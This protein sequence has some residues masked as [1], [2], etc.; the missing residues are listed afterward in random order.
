MSTPEQPLNKICP[1]CGST[2]FMA[3]ITRGGIVK[4]TAVPGDE[5]GN[6]IE[7]MKEIPDKHDVA[8][9]KCARCRNDIT[10]EDLTTGI[11][12]KSCGTDTPPDDIDENGNCGVCAALAQRTELQTASKEDLIRMLIEAERKMNPVNAQIEKKQQL[13]ENTINTNTD[14]A[15]D[16]TQE[17]QVESEEKPQRKTRKRK[18]A[19]ATAEEN[20]IEEEAAEPDSEEA[21]E[22]QE[23]PAQ[24]QEDVDTI[25]NQQEAPFPDGLQ[26][27][28]AISIEK[29]GEFLPLFNET[30]TE[31]P[32]EEKPEEKFEMFD[33]SDDV[34]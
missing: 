31:P 27:I 8:V 30:N 11:K 12:C 29:D 6:N 10:L 17:E 3:T 32:S 5:K 16:D 7:I 20:T 9:V 15:P 4:V 21:P 25:A 13:A 24:Q 2:M 28:D 14:T 1:H 34:I 18:N 19:K 33:D 22:Q 23:D 26:E